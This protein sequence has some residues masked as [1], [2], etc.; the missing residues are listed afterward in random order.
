[1][2]DFEKTLMAI[3]EKKRWEKRE[4]EILERLEEVRSKK[5]KLKKKAKELKKRIRRAEDGMRAKRKQSRDVSNTSIDL[6]EEIR[7]M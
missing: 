2:V 6:I 4:K 7:R 5:K 1:M 3:N